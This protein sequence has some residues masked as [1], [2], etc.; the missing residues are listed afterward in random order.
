MYSALPSQHP[1]ACSDLCRVLSFFAIFAAQGSRELQ[2]RCLTASLCTDIKSPDDVL[3]LGIDKYNEEC[4][5]IV[6]RCAMET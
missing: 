6:M 3:A 1:H 2:Q 4:R 5:S